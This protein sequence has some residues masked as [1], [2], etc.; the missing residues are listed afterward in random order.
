MVRCLCGGEETTNKAR[1]KRL[2]CWS[3]SCKAVISPPAGP[4]LQKHHCKLLLTSAHCSASLLRGGNFPFL[5]LAC[6]WLSE[7]CT[8]FSLVLTPHFLISWQWRANFSLFPQSRWS[9]QNLQLEAVCVQGP[10]DLYLQRLALWWGEGLSRWLGRIARY[11]WVSKCQYLCGKQTASFIYSMIKAEMPTSMV[12]ACRTGVMVLFIYVFLQ[13]QYV[14]V[15]EIRVTEAAV[16]YS[17]CHRVKVGRQPWQVA[18]CCLLL[19]SVSI[20]FLNAA[21]IKNRLP[22]K[23]LAPIEDLDKKAIYLFMQNKII[24]CY[25]TCKYYHSNLTRNK[26]MEFTCPLAYQQYDRTLVITLR[27]LSANWFEFPVMMQHC[28]ILFTVDCPSCL[29][30]RVA[31][32]QPLLRSCAIHG[33][34]GSR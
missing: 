20:F 28:H 12:Y 7:E 34:P 4:G 3:R 9:T 8:D 17:T 19:L 27:L 13:F 5:L 32:R 14:L 11:L 6:R 24:L 21:C 18:T 16:A 31:K 2:H 30:W 10:G 22:S 26:T 25:L 23:Y 15:P 1:T 29:H 33:F